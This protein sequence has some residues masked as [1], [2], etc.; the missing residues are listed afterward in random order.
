MSIETIEKAAV[1][2]V[3]A[4]SIG[5]AVAYYLVK[6]Q[7]LNH[8]YP[9]CWRCKEP[10]M[11]RATAQWFISMDSLQLRAKALA[12]INEVSWTPAW[13]QQRIYPYYYYKLISCL[14]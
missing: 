2:V 11:Y 5:I 8:S 6:E 14:C 3:G 12:A 13:G 1:A 7:V 10:V 4:G 9:H